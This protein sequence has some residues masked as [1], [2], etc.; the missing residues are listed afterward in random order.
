M[1]EQMSGWMN[2]W[3]DGWMNEQMSGW[4]DGS[5]PVHV[6]MYRL[7]LSYTHLSPAPVT[8]ITVFIFN[9]VGVAGYQ[10]P[11]PSSLLI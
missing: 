3:M 8:L 5:G 9:S 2:E 4:M 10:N 6:C 11:F 7:L 1:N